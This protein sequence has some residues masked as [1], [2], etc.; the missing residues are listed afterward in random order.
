MVCTA[1][2][3]FCPLMAAMKATNPFILASVFVRLRL[4]AGSPA[5][6]TAAADVVCFPQQQHHTLAGNHPPAY[7]SMVHVPG[8]FKSSELMKEPTAH[9]CCSRQMQHSGTGYDGSDMQ[10]GAMLL[11][12]S[13]GGA[14]ND[15]YSPFH[16]LNVHTAYVSCNGYVI[17]VTRTSRTNSCEA[18]ATGTV[19]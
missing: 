12:F 3:G 4:I 13:S 10:L 8:R 9:P 14:A 19:C 7:E 1:A 18:S 6:A 2:R 15:L 11:L 16:P 5:A 17:R